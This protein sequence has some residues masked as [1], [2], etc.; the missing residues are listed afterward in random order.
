M[1]ERMLKEKNMSIYQCSKSSGIPYTTLSEICQELF[2]IFSHQMGNFRE[3]LNH[4][5][6]KV[7][8]PFPNE[9]HIS[10]IATIFQVAK[11][12]TRTFTILSLDSELRLNN[13]QS[14]PPNVMVKTFNY[15]KVSSTIT[16][17]DRLETCKRTGGIDK[18]NRSNHVVIFL[19]HEGIIHLINLFVKLCFE[20]FRFN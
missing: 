18:L 15:H 1:V 17:T 5:H 12:I 6:L 14:I 16:E 19:V 2:W 20:F 13:A 9:F 11:H 7:I 10:H 8:R 4:L 3:K